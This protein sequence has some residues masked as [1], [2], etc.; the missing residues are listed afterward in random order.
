MAQVDLVKVVEED[1]DHKTNLHLM[2]VQDGEEDHPEEDQ[3]Q[4]QDLDL[5]L[6]QDP[7]VDLDRDRE[8]LVDHHLVQIEI[9]LIIIPTV[10][11]IIIIM[12]M[13]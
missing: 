3:D 2:I 12:M 4:D 11:E 9:L 5:D 7:E 10:L 1:M 6:D 8:D 13:E